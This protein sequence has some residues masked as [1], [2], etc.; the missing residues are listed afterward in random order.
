MEKISLDLF[1][2]YSFLSDLTVYKD[3]LLFHE[4]R[5]DRLSNDY[6]VKVH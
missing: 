4:Y 5:Q 2:E 6:V 3:S 1:L